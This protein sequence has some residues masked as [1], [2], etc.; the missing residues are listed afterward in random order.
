MRI[1]PAPGEKGHTV[2]HGFHTGWE[3]KPGWPRQRAGAATRLAPSSPRVLPPV[4]QPGGTRSASR[5]RHEGCARQ[6]GRMRRP[7]GVWGRTPPGR[8]DRT[9]LLTE[10]AAPQGG[11]PEARLRTPPTRPVPASRG[12]LSAGIS[13]AGAVGG[14]T[15]RRGRFP[16]GPHRPARSRR[17]PGDGWPGRRADDEPFR[18]NGC[19]QADARGDPHQAQGQPGHDRGRSSPARSPHVSARDRSLISRAMRGAHA[20]DPPHPSLPPLGTREPRCGT[21]GALS[22]G[23]P[24]SQAD[25]QSGLVP[26]HPTVTDPVDTRSPQQRHPR[27][28]SATIATAENRAHG[29]IGQR[30]SAQAGAAP[31]DTADP[32]PTRGW[33]RPRAWERQPG[34]FGTRAGSPVPARHVRGCDLNT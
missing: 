3:R 22:A 16:R 34:E 4:S 30:H 15:V 8:V 20:A 11:T 24:L 26:T 12:R 1:A 32:A 2:E 27:R 9:S 21:T 10:G 23:T 7:G 25:A 28:R 19:E 5:G 13:A 18:G 33:I 6:D 17:W 31:G 29:R 14:G